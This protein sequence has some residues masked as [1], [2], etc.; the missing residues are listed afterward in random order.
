MNKTYDFNGNINSNSGIYEAFYAEVVTPALRDRE[1]LR[2]GVG[3]VQKIRSA[4]AGATAKRLAIV[5]GV[6]GSLMGIV[7]IAGGIQHGKISVLGGLCVAAA[8]VAVEYLC[9]K[10]LEKQAAGK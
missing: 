2:R 10:R 1:A 4:L 6:V 9:L 5:G 8:F 3:M 7:G